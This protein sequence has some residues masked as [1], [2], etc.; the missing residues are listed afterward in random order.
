MLEVLA[1]GVGDTFTLKHHTSAVLIRCGGFHLAVDCPDSYGRALL[2]ASA[3]SGAGIG[4]SEIDHVLITHVHGDHMNGLEGLAFYK[5]FAEGKRL[6]LLASNEVRAVVWEER[7]KAPMG[8]LWDGHAHRS[9]RFE[10]YFDFQQLRWED[11]TVVGPL[12]IRARRTIHHIPTS[13]LLVTAEGRTL[14]YSADT[15]FDPGLIDFLAPADLI[16][17]ETNLGPGHTP[18]AALEEL[19]EE[20]RRKMRLYHYP[21]GLELG[22]GSIRLLREGELLRV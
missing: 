1:L 15:A 5:R 12:R 8:T 3:R 16:L 11:E 6:Q 13:A 17:H 4:L 18:A 14:G 9:M 2:E 7:L 20:V 22:Y 19:P 21:D 10:D